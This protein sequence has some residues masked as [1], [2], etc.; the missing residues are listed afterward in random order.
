MSEPMHGIKTWKHGKATS[1]NGTVHELRFDMPFASEEQR[2]LGHIDF[3]RVQ[4]L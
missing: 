4:N 3:K 2:I 1:L